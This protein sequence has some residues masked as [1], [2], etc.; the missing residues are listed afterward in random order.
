MSWSAEIN[1]LSV[2]EDIKFGDV[3]SVTD[4]LWQ[5]QELEVQITAAV[6]NS[7]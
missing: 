4:I 7:Y 1:K 5:V 3:S 2:I 6:K